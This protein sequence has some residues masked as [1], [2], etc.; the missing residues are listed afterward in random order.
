[1]TSEDVIEQ[2]DDGIAV[3]TLNA[4]A[5]RNALSLEMRESLRERLRNATASRD[6]RALVLTGA[7]GTFSAGGDI[8]KMLIPGEL[9]DPML[10]RQRLDVLHDIV[11]LLVAGPKPVVAAVE[12]HAFGAGFSLALACDHVVAA[13]GASFSAAFGRMGLVADC[14]LLWT[15]PQRAG[16]G[17]TRDLLLTGRT[18]DAAEA[19]RLGIAD[20]LAPKG[21]ALAVALR[22]ARQYLS[23][24][25]LAIAA[26]KSAL[27]RHP[28]SLDEALSI[29]ADLQASLRVS[30]DH[31]E[32]CQ[33]FFARRPAIFRGR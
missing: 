15:L 20:T 31:A 9:P 19:H 3:L 21:Q 1:M 24:A 32:A 33:A 28:A 4:V 22:Q 6:I 27:A 12:G 2:V 29:E 18:V 16:I 10:A 17:C 14:G 23:I 5:R 25:P 26:T 8:R 7:Q 11:R 13:E 30:H